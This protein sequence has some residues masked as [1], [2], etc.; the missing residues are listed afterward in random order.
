M[1]TTAAVARRAGWYHGWNVVGACV[2]SQVVALGLTLSCFSLFLPIWSKE[3]GAPVSTLA[4]AVTIFSLGCALVVPFAGVLADRYPARWLFGPALAGLAVLH[5]AVGFVTQTW[6]MILL[7]ALPLP[8]L[9]SFAAAV[10]A[11]ALVSRWFVKRVGLAMGITALGVKAGGIV[12][13]PLVV[14]LLAQIGWRETW[15]LGGG[16]IGLL[17]LPAVVL[18]MRDRPGAHDRQDYVGGGPVAAAL[19]ARLAT[20]D[21]FRRRTFW[22]LVAV[23]VPVQCVAMTIVVNLG[24]LIV[25]GG[26][27][28]SAAGGALALSAMAGV[29]GMLLSGVAADRLGNRL[30][31]VAVSLAA[32]AGAAMLAFGASDLTLISAAMVL[33]GLSGGLWT[34]LASA[35]AAEFGP[36]GFGRAFGLISAFTPFGSLAAPLVARAQETTGTYTAAFM[37]LAVFAL[38]GAGAALTLNQPRRRP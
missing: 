29:V 33:T 20:K 21:V 23:L 12:A 4:S 10:P 27:D 26:H 11:Q 25:N 34:L 3:F 28:V 15:W 37:A 31:L 24:P 9:I 19:G 1:S 18:A 2:L 6:Q 7:Y 16:V 13:P 5:V 8:L 35:T 38:V 36:Q 30:P 32:A 22:V 17:V 14:L